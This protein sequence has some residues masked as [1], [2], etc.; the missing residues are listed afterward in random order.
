[1]D[2][3]ECPVCEQS[4]GFPCTRRFMPPTATLRVL[5]LDGGGVKGLVQLHILEHLL[6]KI[7]LREG[8]H[9]SSFFDLM[10]GSSIGNDPRP[11]SVV[12]KKLL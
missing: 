6:D 12:V 2:V 7:G 9:I 4:V 8:V 1:M 10:V 5:A 11:Y 3:H